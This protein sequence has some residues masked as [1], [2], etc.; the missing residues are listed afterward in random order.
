MII[1]C[2]IGFVRH[3]P[4]A[5]RI[6][7]VL[8]AAA[9]GVFGDVRVSPLFSNHAVLQRGKPVRVWGWADPG[10]G[11][12][13]QFAG[14]TR[15]TRTAEDGKWSIELAPLSANRQPTTLTVRGHT[16]VEIRDLLVGEVWLC[17]GQSNMEWPLARSF[18][19]ESD[20]QSSANPQIRLFTVRKNRSP[21]PLENFGKPTEHFWATANPE[22]VRDFSAVGYY[23][24]RD[25]Q[26][27]LGVPVGL[28]HTSWGGSPAEVWMSE[29][30]LRS[31]H[32]HQREILDEYARR[33][34]AQP[35]NLAN[36]AGERAIAEKLKQPF[37]RPRPTLGWA[38]AELYNAMIHPLVPYGM[39]GAIW[40]Q[41]ESNVGRALQYRTLFAD[42]ITH[43]R[44]EFRQG[45]FPFL[46]VQ[47]A[48]WDQGR[49]RSLEEITAVPAESDWAE[50]RDAQNHVA[51]TL[52]HVGIAVITDLGDPDDIHPP[53][54][55]PVGARL[56]RL[57]QRIAY[58]RQISASGPVLRSATPVTGGFH[59][60]FGE[61]SG[62]L[63]TA[64]GRPPTGFAIAGADGVWR[65]AHA[66]ISGANRV[67]LTH[68]DVPE[69]IA[70]RHG[71]ADFPVVNLTGGDGLPASPFRTDHGQ[72]GTARK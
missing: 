60:V 72:L 26:A 53:R 13:V 63:K 28:I 2:L 62:G 25:L 6:A 49:R 12:Q 8:L 58:Q 38:P 66:T 24:G 30:M 54:K 71:W 69:P 21:V 50:L 35:E 56:S 34:Q 39:A 57:A 45:D 22:T 47:L 5:T 17:S 16:T 32:V 51:R 15:T 27:A 18:Q 44:K 55:A 70:V 65:W 43:W 64:D 7:V 67:H 41:G 59:L 48:P 37:T 29:S 31:N 40:Y 68:P 20:I 4:W 11:V 23:F 10:E 36:W 46:A 19:P 3:L 9:P 52:R 61:T 1:P 42:L 33:L 14:Q